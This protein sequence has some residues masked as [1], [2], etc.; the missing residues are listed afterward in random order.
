MFIL[1]L[2]F[3][4]Y[5]R[6]EWMKV[7]VRCSKFE[8]REDIHFKIIVVNLFDYSCFVDFVSV[9]LGRRGNKSVINHI[10]VIISGCVIF[11]A[12]FGYIDEFSPRSGSWVIRTTSKNT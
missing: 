7:K 1:I 5:T 8:C 4:I 3:G 2:I 6:C 12:F 9:F 11:A 10:L